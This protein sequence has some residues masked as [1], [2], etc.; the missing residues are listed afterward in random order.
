MGIDFKNKFTTASIF[1]GV[2]II[3]MLLLAF[4]KNMVKKK[5]KM[6]ESDPYS[7]KT[8][9]NHV[10][11]PKQ[12]ITLIQVAGEKIL[13]GVTPD[14][15]S[16][17]T[18]IDSR[19]KGLPSDN[20]LEGTIRGPMAIRAETSPLLTSR[21]GS[22]S[23]A[24]E[25]IKSLRKGAVKPSFDEEIDNHE[26]DEMNPLSRPV[27]ASEPKKF[28]KEISRTKA[29]PKGSSVSYAVGDNGIKDL[30]NSRSAR[31]AGTDSSEDVTSMIRKKLKNLPQI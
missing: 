3:G 14:N 20:L 21:S 30:R 15:I 12:K 24:L 8:L 1:S 13:L 17:L 27:P 16:F 19:P 2:F 26:H 6:R 5:I 25:K 10:L 18:S 11:S 9:A 7:I 4:S 28:K 29:E 31:S 23:A 22:A